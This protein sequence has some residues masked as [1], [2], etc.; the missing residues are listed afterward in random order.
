M[1]GQKCLL[2]GQIQPG[3]CCWWQ[4]GAGAPGQGDVPVGVGFVQGDQGDAGVLVLVR[5]HA[6]QEGDAQPCRHQVDDEVDLPAA[7][8]YLRHG[9]HCGY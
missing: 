9:G 8:G 2:F 1:S 4:V 3:P 5:E 6:W 7:G